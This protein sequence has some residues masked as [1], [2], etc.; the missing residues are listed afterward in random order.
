HDPRDTGQITLRLGIGGRAVRE[1]LALARERFRLVG[2]L[3]TVDDAEAGGDVLACRVILDVEVGGVHHLPD[4]AQVRLAVR[5][6]RYGLRAGDTG[7]E[8]DRGHHRCRSL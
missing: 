7:K 8:Q 6:S 3:V 4:A 5:G 1:V 2:D